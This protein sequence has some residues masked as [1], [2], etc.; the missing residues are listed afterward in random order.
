MSGTQ[1]TN[2]NFVY[3]YQPVSQS[4]SGPAPHGNGYLY[5]P[6]SVP[7]ELKGDDFNSSIRFI[8]TGG[9][10]Q[11]YYALVQGFQLSR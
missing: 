6:Q 9:G 4:D 5:P 3:T 8:G 7:Q 11:S 2:C 1:M 10:Y